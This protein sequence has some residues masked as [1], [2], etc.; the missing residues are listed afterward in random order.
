MRQYLG[1]A[2]NPF[3]LPLSKEKH[4]MSPC[5]GCAAKWIPFED[6]SSEDEPL[7]SDDEEPPPGD[8]S[9]ISL[10]ANQDDDE[11]APPVQENP[12]RPGKIRTLF[13][14]ETPPDD[15]AWRSE[16][17]STYSTKNDEWRTHWEQFRVGAID[18]NAWDAYRAKVRAEHANPIGHPITMREDNPGMSRCPECTDTYVCWKDRS[19]T[20]KRLREPEKK[21]YPMHQCS[22][23]SG[24]FDCKKDHPKCSNC[25]NTVH[26]CSRCKP[27]KTCVRCTTRPHI[28]NSK[29]ARVCRF[30][31]APVCPCP[32]GPRRFQSQKDN[33]NKG[34]FFWTCRDCN[35]FEWE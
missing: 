22:G 35:L 11:E 15:A 12:N 14:E 8:E 32:S 25:D 27:V 34:R 24:A 3:D 16:R 19:K 10:Y 1:Y 30:K 2:A 5:F 20:A 23:C 6:P 9:M 31:K 26:I 7:S 33:D 29:C 4:K 28:C 17:R 21:D 18:L 13:I